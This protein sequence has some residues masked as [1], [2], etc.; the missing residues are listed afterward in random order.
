[1]L[2]IHLSVIT[3]LLRRSFILLMSTRA[4]WEQRK[5]HHITFIPEKIMFPVRT[6]RICF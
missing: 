5:K 6:Q 1:M 2:Y 3:A 4:R